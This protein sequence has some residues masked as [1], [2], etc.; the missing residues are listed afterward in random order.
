VDAETGH[1]LNTKATKITKVTKTVMVFGLVVVAMSACAPVNPSQRAIAGQWKVK[2]SCGSEVLD[3]KPDG[4]Y[5]YAIDFST[6]GRAT[7]SGRWKVVPKTSR[8]TG[9]HVVLQNAL[10]TCSVSGEKTL[11]AER[12]DR[13]L[14]TIWE[15]GRM[16]LSFD[17]DGEGFTRR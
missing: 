17:P 11:T 16:I 2:W 3:L 9:A 6:D 13:E 12:G 10:T 5:T 4:T 1:A 8:L 14:E 7:D 15:W